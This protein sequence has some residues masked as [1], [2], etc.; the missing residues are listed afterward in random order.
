MNKRNHTKKNNA[1]LKDQ[2]KL[3]GVTVVSMD[4]EIDNITANLNKAAI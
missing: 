1:T 4:I 2:S 3:L